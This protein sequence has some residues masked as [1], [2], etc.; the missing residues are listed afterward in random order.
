MTLWKTIN[1]HFERRFTNSLMK[2]RKRINLLEHTDYNELEKE[3]FGESFSL[4]NIE[5][6]AKNEPEKNQKKLC[7]RLKK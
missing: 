7:F 1:K 6:N 5:I 4:N 2:R 3:L